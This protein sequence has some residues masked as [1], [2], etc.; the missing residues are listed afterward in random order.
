MSSARSCFFFANIS[1]FIWTFH[2]LFFCVFWHQWR[3]FSFVR[4]HSAGLM[5]PSVRTLKNGGGWRPWLG[6]NFPPKLEHER[7]GCAWF[8]ARTKWIWPKNRGFVRDISIRSRL[9]QMVMPKAIP[10]TFSGIILVSLEKNVPPQLLTANTGA[11]ASGM[12]LYTGSC[13]D[14]PREWKLPR[15]A[16]FEIFVPI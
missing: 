11:S 1:T 15:L 16:N 13:S 4:L 2:S 12:G 10:N 8:A 9:I 5:I 7:H 6:W 3:W 14:D